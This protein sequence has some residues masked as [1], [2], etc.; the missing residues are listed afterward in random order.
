[1]EYEGGFGVH[2]LG[3]EPY[4]QL[5]RITLLAKLTTPFK[6]DNGPTVEDYRVVRQ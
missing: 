5:L 4:F 1:M 3:Y 6:F 2:D